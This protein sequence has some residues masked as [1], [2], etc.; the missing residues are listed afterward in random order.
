MF[1]YLM[2]SYSMFP[3][4]CSHT[5]S[6]ASIAVFRRFAI[7]LVTVERD[8]AT[9]RYA[10][11]HLKPS[12]QPLVILLE[13]IGQVFWLHIWCLNHFPIKVRQLICKGI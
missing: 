12:Q 10:T 11:L 9:F 6:L 4:P 2:L 13:P 3:Y 1:P 5:N 7:L 8:R